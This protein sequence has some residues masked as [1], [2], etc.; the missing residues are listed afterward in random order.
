MQQMIKILGKKFW[1]SFMDVV[2]ILLVIIFFQVFVIQKP[3]P[4]LAESL[5]GLFLVVG[6]LFIFMMGLETAL[7]PIGEKMAGQFAQKGSGA[8]VIF[9]DLPWGF[10]PPLRNRLSRSLPK[11][12]A[13]LPFREMRLIPDLWIISF[14]G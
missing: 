10:P 13:N 14:S 4:N 2:P 11:K 9:L 12:P 1:A 5:F 6:G 8:W 3:F 7:F